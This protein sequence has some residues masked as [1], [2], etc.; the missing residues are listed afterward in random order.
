MNQVLHLWGLTSFKKNLWFDWVSGASHAQRVQA[1]TCPWATLCYI[2]FL[3][4]L[5]LTLIPF[6][7]VKPRW[8][9]KRSWRVRGHW[10]PSACRWFSH[11]LC[12]EVCSKSLSELHFGSWSQ[13]PYLSAPCR[14]S[15]TRLKFEITVTN[16][17]HAHISEVGSKEQMPMLCWRFMGSMELH[18]LPN[19]LDE[20]HV[21]WMI[22]CWYSLHAYYS[23]TP[24]YNTIISATGV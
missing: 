17:L 1:F 19:F 3:V 12:F 21:K 24:V 8:G 20:N 5:C 23:A 13:D 9:P 22:H 18:V 16:F 6:R 10:I 7:S 4:K 14:T 2:S 11:P 15:A